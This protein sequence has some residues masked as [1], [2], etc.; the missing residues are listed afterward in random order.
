MLGILALAG[1]PREQSQ[2]IAEKTL[3]RAVQHHSRL[4]DDDFLY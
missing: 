1:I 2:S 4:L 3:T